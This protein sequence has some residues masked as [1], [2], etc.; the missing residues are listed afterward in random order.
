MQNACK[1]N[2]LKEKVARGN[3]GVKLANRW[4]GVTP[5]TSIP[6]RKD[7]CGR[8]GDRRGKRDCISI[9]VYGVMQLEDVAFALR[10]HSGNKIELGNHQSSR[11]VSLATST[12]P[13]GIC[14]VCI[15]RDAVK[16]H[17]NVFL[18]NWFPTNPRLD[19][20]GFAG[21]ESSRGFEDWQRV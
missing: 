1:A 13:R 21:R 4:L 11:V 9:A 8:E 15:F 16:L 3:V 14:S 7:D 20:F 10:Q 2:G 19:L 18:G 12:R 5:V 17:G 6:T